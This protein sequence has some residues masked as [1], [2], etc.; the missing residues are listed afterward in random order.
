[1]NATDVVQLV[2]AWANDPQTHNADL[3]GSIVNATAPVQ[4]ISFNAI[5]QLPDVSIANADHMEETVLPAEVIGNKYIVVPPTT[6]NGNAVGHVVRIYGNVNGT[7]LTYPEGAP[8]GA[9]TVINAG[10][11]VQIPPLHK[12]ERA[13]LCVK[14]PTHCKT[15]RH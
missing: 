4:V 15:N 9:P 8:P 14:D 1:M 3:S 7:N 2:G 6:P 10:E 12:R 11:V 13:P 5:A